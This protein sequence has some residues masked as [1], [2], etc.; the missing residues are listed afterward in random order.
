MFSVA[1]RRH[2]APVAISA[3]TPLL[4]QAFLIL[5]SAVA[6]AVADLLMGSF[7]PLYAEKCNVCKTRSSFPFWMDI[8]GCGDGTNP[9]AICAVCRESCSQRA[10]HLLYFRDC[11][12]SVSEGVWIFLCTKQRQIVKKEFL[13][14]ACR[15][16]ASPFLSLTYHRSGEQAIFQGTEVELIDHIFTYIGF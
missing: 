11:P 1:P 12:T 13:L 7:S 10:F 4:L 8:D 2:M 9:T 14:Q 3:P 6:S 5:A 15:A 16:R